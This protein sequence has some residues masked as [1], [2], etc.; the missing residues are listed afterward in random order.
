MLQ[1]V[2]WSVY[3]CNRKDDE[4]MIL[5]SSQFLAFDVSLSQDYRK[6]FCGPNLMMRGVCTPQ[7]LVWVGGTLMQ[8]DSP[9]ITR[10]FRHISRYLQST[11]KT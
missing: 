4:I 1:L 6:L 5:R 11:S 7:K 2:S 8:I 9:K 3:H 10:H